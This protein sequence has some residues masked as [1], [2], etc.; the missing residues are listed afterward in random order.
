M[1]RKTISQR[2]ALDGGKEIAD[3]LKKLGA[4]G[5]KAFDQI[6]DAAKKAGSPGA[7]LAK[8]LQNL[9]REFA[10]LG[11][12]GQKLRSDLNNLGSAF[13]TVAAR[14]G[15]AIA[16]V[17]GAA[18]G[19][20]K[21][22][23]A[24]TDAVDAANEQAQAVGLSIQ[25]YTELRFAAEQSGA[26][27]ETFGKA[28]NKLNSLI[29]D[30]ASGNEKAAEKFTALGISLTDLQ[31]N[32]KPTE[33]VFAELADRFAGMPDGAAKSALAIDLLGARAVSLIP[34]LNAGSKGIL[35]F[36]KE[37]QRLGVTLT[38]ADKNTADAFGDTVDAV[39]VA[40]GALR[41]ELA[42]IFAPALTEAGRAFIEV[43]TQNSKAIQDFASSALARVTPLIKDFVN[44]LSGNDAAVQSRWVIDAREAVIG[45]GEAV[46][47][48]VM[49][50]IIPAFTLLT[51]AATVV[52]EAF[53]GIFGTDFTGQELLVTASIVKLIGGFELLGAA[54]AVGISSVKLAVAAFGLLGPATTVII[55]AFGLLGPLFTTVG[56]AL[57]ALVGW[58]ALIIAGIVAAGILIYKFWDEIVAGA[59][60]AL[61]LVV[62]VFKGAGKLIAAGL[63]LGLDAVKF[64]W[65]G[66]VAGAKGAWSLLMDGF[67]GVWDYITNGFNSLVGAIDRAISRIK[68]IIASIKSALKSAIS[69]AEG[70]GVS[71]GSTSYFAEGGRVRGPGTGTSDSIVA[72]LS[73]G[74]FVNRTASVR[75]YGA[76]LFDALNKMRIP[77]DRLA[78][79]LRAIKGGGAAFRQG[80]VVKGGRDVP[81]FATGGLVSLRQIEI[82]RFA[83]GGLATGDFAALPAA[84]LESLTAGMGMKGPT[85]GEP[86]VAPARPAGR[87][88]SLTIGD[89]II[90]GLTATDDAVQQLS[91]AAA[92]RSLRS[93]GRAPGWTA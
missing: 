72:R 29:V 56:T 76:E 31:G 67:R 45:F 89:Q 11:A 8:S 78:A 38:D 10:T 37:A 40:A 68:S 24:G 59:K 4:A 21:F 93:L 48:A 12:A 54:I 25:S 60:M 55:T 52:A 87:P 90:E 1:A 82:P 3:E 70:S 85:F 88:L 28:I 46:N 22:T 39:G 75:Y 5:E 62:D 58:P 14:S 34:L 61:G 35:D 20:V 92:N 79:A 91:R 17:T 33:A 81:A 50:V 57:A 53:N 13:G 23:K 42:L 6:A 26:S 64:V 83:M 19:L 43:I 69:S 49:S 73:N 41:T 2:I 9:R 63:T 77:R 84:L 16:A 18:V 32:L 71:Y 74:E 86:A 51:D 47:T 44:A 30:A 65:N 36:R 66:L 15:I 27:Q 7:Q 80:G